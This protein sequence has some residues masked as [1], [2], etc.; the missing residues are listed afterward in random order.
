MIL[1]VFDAARHAQPIALASLIVRTKAS[2]MR[3][4]SI[5]RRKQYNHERVG[6]AEAMSRFDGYFYFVSGSS[7]KGKGDNSS[8]RKNLCR[9]QSKNGRRTSLVY[10]HSYLY[11]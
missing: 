7:W 6:C 1:E 8:M 4:G 2:D 10:I 9:D 5:Q 11:S 3:R